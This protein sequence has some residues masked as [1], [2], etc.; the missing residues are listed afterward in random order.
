MNRS[1]VPTGFEICSH[2]CFNSF[3]SPIT[4]A[5][6]LTSF[7]CKE[8]LNHDN[9][10]IED[11][12][13]SFDQNTICSICLTDFKDPITLLV[14]KHTLCKEC[15][16]NWFKIKLAC[17]LCKTQTNYFIKGEYSTTLKLMQIHNG[18]SQSYDDDI[19]SSAVSRHITIC[20]NKKRKYTHDQTM[21]NSFIKIGLYESLFENTDF[22]LDS[23]EIPQ[24]NN[25][26]I[27]KWF[28]DKCIKYKRG[29]IKY[30]K[31]KGSYLNFSF[32]TRSVNEDNKE[33]QNT[34]FSVI[35]NTKAEDYILLDIEHVFVPKKFR[36]HGV[37]EILTKK[38]LEIA[39]NYKIKIQP[40]C[41]YVRETF[42]IKHKRLALEFLN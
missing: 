40:S 22:T 37:A 16:Y 30:N 14:C 13:S 19:L 25:F 21:L 4:F 38:A 17:P 1:I 10:E 9:A 5:K 3:E 31:C 27:N 39:E 35:S 29:T 42:F 23:F 26:L 12:S 11:G 32:S 6:D 34:H 41:S 20:K 18:I 36:G 2:R 7:E 24:E 28:F 8:E 15:A 33:W